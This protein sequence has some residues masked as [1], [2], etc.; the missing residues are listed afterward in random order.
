MKNDGLLAVTKPLRKD[1]KPDKRGTEKPILT[2]KGMATLIIDGNL[3]KEEL[4]SALRKLLQTGFTRV[5]DIFWR[6]MPI[7]PI[8]D[9]VLKMKPKVNLNDFD[10]EYFTKTLLTDLFEGFTSKS[11]ADSFSENLGKMNLT[12]K[13]LSDALKIYDMC[14]KVAVKEGFPKQPLEDMFEWGKH[15]GAEA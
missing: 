5:P 11:F 4:I 15:L 8:A 2:P 1:G 7:E 9:I 6:I 10:E 3:Q 12:K 14:N 13:E